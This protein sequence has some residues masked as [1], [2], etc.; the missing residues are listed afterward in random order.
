LIPQNAG[1][2]D[3]VIHVGRKPNMPPVCFSD[4]DG[5]MEKFRCPVTGQSC[6][7][8]CFAQG[9]N[10]GPPLV[11]VIL[12]REGLDPGDAFLNMLGLLAALE[13]VDYLSDEPSDAEFQG[14]DEPDLWTSF[15]N[16]GGL[17]GVHRRPV[18]A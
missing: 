14:A 2:A 15:K 5:T 16:T 13:A 17:R 7:H 11:L 6:E 12:S 18:H 10:S 8:G 9:E 4:G 1:S 3:G